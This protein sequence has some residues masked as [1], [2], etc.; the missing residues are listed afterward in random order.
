[1]S[2]QKSAYKNQLFKRMFRRLFIFSYRERVNSSFALITNGFAMRHA[3]LQLITQTAGRKFI[4]TIGHNYYVIDISVSLKRSTVL[5]WASD[6]NRFSI[7]Q[8][9]AATPLLVCAY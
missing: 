3:V 8:G 6:L 2:H 9:E 5:R 1:M 7:N 4:Y